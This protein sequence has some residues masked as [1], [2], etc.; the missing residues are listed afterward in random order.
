[1]SKKRF[2][3]NENSN[4]IKEHS[5]KRV[6]VENIDE[7]YTRDVFELIKSNE[8]LKRIWMSMITSYTL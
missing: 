5:H 3:I 7:L 2:K 6:L 8:E 1:M 4:V